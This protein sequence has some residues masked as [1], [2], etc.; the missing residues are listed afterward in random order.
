M[1]IKSS[2]AKEM[3]PAALDE[4]IKEATAKANEQIADTL[5]NR[6]HRSK[7]TA[8]EGPQKMALE[9]QADE[10]FYGGAAGGGKTDLIL[11]AAFTQHTKSAIFR[12]RLTDLTHIETRAK[13]IAGKRGSY[14]QGDYIWRMNDGRIIEFGGCEKMSSW[15]QW[16]GRPHDFK[17]FDEIP[18]FLQ[19]M[20]ILIKAWTR[21]DVPDQRVRNICTGNPPT[22]MQGD[23]VLDYWGPWINP[24]HP[25]YPV[26]AGELRWFVS[27]GDNVNVMVENS[28]PVMVN[29][30]ELFP[31]SRT[32]I[33]ALVTDNPYYVNTDYARKLNSLPEPFRS[34]MLWGKFNVGRKDKRF[35]VIPS[36]WVKLAQNRW[37]EWR[38]SGFKS[39]LGMTSMGVDFA[40]GGQAGDKSTFAPIYD[41]TK[42]K[43]ID[44]LEPSTDEHFATIATADAVKEYLVGNNSAVVFVDGRGWGLGALEILQADPRY[45]AIFG[46]DA[47]RKTE[48]TDQSG[49]LQFI[50]WRAAA[51]WITRE[52]LDP[53]NGLDIMIPDDPK[54]ERQLCTPTYELTQ[55]GKIK[56]ESKE[57]LRERLGSSTD[58]AD[59]AISGLT[60]IHLQ[61]AEMEQE[62]FLTEYNPV[63]V[64]HHF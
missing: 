21:T 28:D 3:S 50:N 53:K 10:L 22:D 45:P 55:M 37:R 49:M 25:E 46:F 43:S 4:M 23:W 56:L 12:R 40:K 32:F 64:H 54:L 15:E 52:M 60:G 26:P 14:N 30:E 5:E 35:Q 41:W 9:N 29:N 51:W 31:S 48:L 13:E 38:E 16:Q 6:K 36:A 39:G 27:V 2:I 62:Q 18:Q 17:A 44:Y 11:G 57:K 42:V 7:W 59:A 20:Y 58:E 24:H 34:Q 1:K 19:Q 33:P 8:N 63:K 47:S 61:L